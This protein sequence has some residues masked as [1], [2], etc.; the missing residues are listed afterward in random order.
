MNALYE[1][2]FRDSPHRKDFNDVMTQEDW[3]LLY[4]K[5][6]HSPWFLREFFT[7]LESDV[8]D[9]PQHHWGVFKVLDILIAWCLFVHYKVYNLLWDFEKQKWVKSE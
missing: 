4:I 7:F 9:W 8:Y 5:K 2:V 6:T 3:Q 1:G